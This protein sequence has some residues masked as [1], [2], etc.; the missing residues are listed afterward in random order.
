MGIACVK[1]EV[2]TGFTGFTIGKSLIH[3]WNG[4]NGH[5]QGLGLKRS[6]VVV[7]KDDGETVKEDR[8]V[9]RIEGQ[10]WSEPANNKKNC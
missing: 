4:H 10:T 1:G 7:G 2:T 3:F 5:G 9:G 6:F 8:Q